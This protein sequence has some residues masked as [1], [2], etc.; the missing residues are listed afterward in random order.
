LDDPPELQ[1]PNRSVKYKVRYQ[2]GAP[3]VKLR[4]EVTPSVLHQFHPEYNEQHVR[5]DSHPI[6]NVEEHGQHRGEE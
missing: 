5:A 6:A 1:E 2:R 3:H 4:K